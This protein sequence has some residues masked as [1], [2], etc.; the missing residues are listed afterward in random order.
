MF[1]EVS[2]SFDELLLS[3]HGWQQT[4]W[5]TARGIDCHYLGPYAVE[6]KQTRESRV[7]KRFGD[8]FGFCTT[9]ACRG[10]PLCLDPDQQSTVL[11]K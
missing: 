11:G 8:W 2:K 6:R 4:P 1:L 3:D 9:S 7:F 10:Q 5:G